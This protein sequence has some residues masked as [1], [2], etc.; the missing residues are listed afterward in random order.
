MTALHRDE[1]RATLSL[2]ASRSVRAKRL[3]G[4]RTICLLTSLPSLLP[5]HM[6]IAL[7]SRRRLPATKTTAKH[8][9]SGTIPRVIHNELG[10]TE[11][12]RSLLHSQ[13]AER[14]PDRARIHRHRGLCMGDSPA[15]CP[16][17]STTS[18]RSRSLAAT[19]DRRWNP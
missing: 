6:P 13:S 3:H 16:G 19:E 15:G 18:S 5:Y 1:K 14:G 4:I 17:I 8:S 9:P 10:N 12:P 7:D 2:T 11:R